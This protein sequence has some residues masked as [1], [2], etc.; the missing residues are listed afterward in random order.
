VIRYAIGSGGH[1]AYEVVPSLADE[2]LLLITDGFVPIDAM[3]VE[4]RLGR[5]LRRLTSIRR[6][7]RFDRRGV[8]A[9]DPL[10][11]DVEPL[12][13]WVD[14]CVTVLDNLGVQR[15]AV[16]GSTETAMIAMALGARHPERVDQLVLFGCSARMTRAPGYDIGAE[17]IG[18]YIEHTTR[19]DPEPLDADVDD[20]TIELVAP[21]AAGDPEFRRW[22][23]DAGRRGC[24]PAVAGR[25]MRAMVVADVRAE[26]P[27]ITARTLV[28]RR[29]DDPITPASHPRY[30]AN[31]IPAAEYVEV[32]GVDNLW[33]VGDATS[34]LDAVE[35]FLT[36]EAARPEPM[37][38]ATLLFTDLVGS[39]SRVTALGDRAWRATLDAHDA[40]VRRVL[41]RN[42]G[43]ERKTTG[44]GFLA[45]F[46]DPLLAACAAL[47]IHAE[48][49]S[50]GLEVR[51]GVHQG[52][53]EVRGEDIAGL[54]V[55][56]A[57][58]IMGLA[59]SGETL[60]SDAVGRVLVDAGA[61][62]VPKGAFE[63]KG[64]AGTWP[65]HMVTSLARE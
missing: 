9:S 18:E 29:R 22:W 13:A 61:E 40:A 4:P 62:L 25:L 37:T 46:D 23:L 11:H 28:V 7:I 53:I 14:D 16:F 6:V 1:I 48:L 8:A 34:L 31:H 12:D 49:S 10:P 44:D 39:T 52:D 32:P 17:G 59:G 2:H 33:W 60:V 57:A 64:I 56:V 63:L 21:S 38:V 19:L 42:Q 65:L 20:A 50:L 3:D 58:R 55:H 30:I 51:C 36:G 41:L 47:E 26:L 27:Q 24:S 15:T 5:A 45:T 35:V 43:R 54:A